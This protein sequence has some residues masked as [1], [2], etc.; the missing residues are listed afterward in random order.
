MSLLIVAGVLLAV[1][2]VG[3]LAIGARYVPP[4]EVLRTLLDALEGRGAGEVHEIV[5]GMRLPRAL[6]GVAV[7]AA[8]G[9]AGA[10]I[11]ALTRNPLA[12]PG[13]LGVNAGAG[14]AV[15]IGI[16][17]FGVGDIDGYVWFSFAGAAVATVLVFAIGAGGP[18]GATPLRLTL[19]GVALGAL[20]GGVA[21]MI[22]LLDPSVF[23]GMRFW[24]AGSLTS[25]DEYVLAAVLPFVLAGLAL[26]AVVATPLNALA[27]GEDLAHSLG[28]GVVR[29][30][31][32][33]VLAVTLLAGAATAAAGPIGFLGLM[34]PHAVRWFVGPDQRWILAGTVVCAPLLLLVADV[35]G[36]VVAPPQE[37]QVGII[38]AFIGAPVLVLLARRRRIT[39]L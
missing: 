28:V 16:G 11:Q 31:V 10:L 7:G 29:T 35:V 30:R 37:L 22:S 26:A 8:L 19:V 3:S 6:V 2:V 20:L 13:I 14:F 12:D 5:V 25:R 33:V 39:A 36:R 21:S 23:D 9:V 27:L 1:T 17:W 34:V 38:T 24:G 4:A 32:L 15:T 18:A